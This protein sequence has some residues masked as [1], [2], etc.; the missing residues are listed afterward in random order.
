M[1]GISITYLLHKLLSL[2][3]FMQF[4]LY[5]EVYLMHMVQTTRHQKWQR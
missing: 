4:K 3:Y 5:I 1:I 2:L